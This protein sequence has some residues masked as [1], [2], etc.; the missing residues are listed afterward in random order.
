MYV[1]K[2]NHTFILEPCKINLNF[3]PEFMLHP[4]VVLNDESPT[5]FRFKSDY[6]EILDLFICPPNIANSMLNFEVLV[7]HMM[8]SDHAPIMCTLGLKK[9]FR[10]EIKPSEPK[11]NF[12]K[13][14]WIEYGHVLDDLI[15]QI[16]FDDDPEKI[17][18]FLGC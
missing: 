11:F 9:N 7:E 15:D 10:L 6:T 12:N 17:S 3:V 5:Y 4:L 13:A 14:D 2:L 18:P 16:G 1:I 8:S